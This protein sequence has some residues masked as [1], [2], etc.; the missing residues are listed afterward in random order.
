MNSSPCIRTSALIL[1]LGCLTTASG[2][3]IYVNNA[4]IAIPATFEGVYLDLSANS[5]SSSTM[6]GAPDAL[7]DS[8]TISYSEPSAADWDFNFFFGGVGIA[9]NSNANPYRDDASDNLSA[10]HALLL[11]DDID[12]NSATASGATPLTSPAFGGS[13]TG[14][15]GG[16]GVSTSGSHVGPGADQ[17]TPNTME[18]LG[19]VL[20]SGTASEQYGWMLVTFQEDGSEGMIHEFVLSDIP[21]SVG[22]I[23]EP[24]AGILL[25]LGA[26]PLLRRRRG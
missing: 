18:Y 23:P 12:G 3:I 7:G 24:S 2:A 26:L 25:V 11:G 16:S 19:F 9:H 5:T 15:G 10:I 4:N 21:V 20:D 13:G 6:T 8:Y 1:S 14:S 22:A 17:F